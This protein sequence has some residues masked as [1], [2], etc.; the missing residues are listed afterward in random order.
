[1]KK[2]N[3]LLMCSLAALSCTIASAN[4]F[5][6]VADTATTAVNSTVNA[7]EDITNTVVPTRTTAAQPMETSN[8]VIVEEPVAVEERVVVVPVP[9][10]VNSVENTEV[11]PVKKHRRQCGSCAEQK[12]CGSCRSC[13]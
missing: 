8:M 3:L 4:L 11:M 5:D 13:E 6:A 9:V 10:Q 12:T 7:A 1:M 2:R